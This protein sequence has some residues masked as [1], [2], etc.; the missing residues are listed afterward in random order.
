MG[1]LHLLIGLLFTCS[2]LCALYRYGFDLNYCAAWRLSRL[3]RDGVWQRFDDFDLFQTFRSVRAA[4][5][6]LEDVVVV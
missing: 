6:H 4:H 3:V 2:R 1:L 5:T